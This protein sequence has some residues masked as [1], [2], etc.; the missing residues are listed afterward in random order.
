MSYLVYQGSLN[1]VVYFL[2]P[3]FKMVMVF[4]SYCFISINDKLLVMKCFSNS[5]VPGFSRNEFNSWVLFNFGYLF[6]FIWH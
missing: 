5:V 6:I 3:D 1:I 2:L 4:L